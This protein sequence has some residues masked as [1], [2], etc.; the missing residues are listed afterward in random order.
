[1]RY[2]NTQIHAY[3]MRGG[4]MLNESAYR[5]LI[6]IRIPNDRETKKSH[7]STYHVR[8][9]FNRHTWFWLHVFALHTEA[10]ELFVYHKS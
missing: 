8:S 7:P 10:P 1:M 5:K 2:P 9:H 3:K 4:L 6:P